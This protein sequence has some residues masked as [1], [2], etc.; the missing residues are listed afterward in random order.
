M[1]FSGVLPPA[2]SLCPVQVTLRNE[3]AHTQGV[4][5]LV[6]LDASNQS[7]VTR[8]LPF[9]LPCPSSKEF[10]LLYRRNESRSVRLRI[11]FQEHFRTVI[12]QIEEPPSEL[13]L[14]LLVDCPPSF[15]G[16]LIAK[17]YRLVPISTRYLPED[18]LV[19]DG[20]YAVVLSSYGLSLLNPKQLFSLR[21]WLFTG[22]RL[23]YQGPRSN[24]SVKQ[25]LDELIRPVK[26]RPG[27][28]AVHIVGLGLVGMGDDSSKGA[29]PFWDRSQGLQKL[30]FPAMKTEEDLAPGGYGSEGLLG[31]MWRPQ[32]GFGLKGFLWIAAILSAYLV[33]ICPLDKWITRKLGRPHFTWITLSVAVFL[34][35]IVAHSYN[36]VVNL[37]TMSEVSVAV[38]NLCPEGNI[39]RCEASYFV[40]SVKNGR[41]SLVPLRQDVH[42][43][44][45]EPELS[46]GSS[47]DVLLSEDTRLLAQARIPV[48]SSKAF[49]CAWYE[50]FDQKLHWTWSNEG[51]L[52]S[53]HLPKGLEVYSVHLAVKEGLVTLKNLGEKE[54]EIHFQGDLSSQTKPWIKESMRI[55][56]RLQR[57][58]SYGGY[59]ASEDIFP[60]MESLEGY[61]L[62]TTLYGA[63]EIEE[64]DEWI[65]HHLSERERAMDLSNLLDIGGVLLLVIQGDAYSPVRVEGAAPEKIHVAG[66][67]VFLQE[68]ER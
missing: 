64:G 67:R 26:V 33:V 60:S 52:F 10:S 47:A 57:A 44:C 39:A 50:T 23:L 29:S 8:S 17:K 65:S 37:G 43:H 53:L 51:T 46:M 56:Q 3:L 25:S 27:R 11:R 7:S 28:S 62:F 63:F 5:E 21:R 31:T 30:F 61:L 15:R 34:F 68:E 1:G 55:T 41:Y 2:G 9:S 32:K 35:S 18:A 13:P 22:G 40:Y 54:G 24:P 4:I 20:V 49:R 59:S 19:F 45:Q 12:E 66:L 58:I 16:S 48:F 38:K 6:Q 14:V 36:R 42:L